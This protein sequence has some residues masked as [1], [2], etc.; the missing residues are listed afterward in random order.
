MKLELFDEFEKYNYQYSSVIFRLLDKN[1]DIMDMILS[2]TNLIHQ[3]IEN[4]IKLY[5]IEPHINNKTAKDLKIDNTHKLEKLLNK[6]ELK[7]YY[8]GI[9]DGEKIYEQY[10]KSVLYFYEILGEDSFLHSRYP[11]QKEKNVITVKKEVDYDELYR[12]WTEYSEAS[13]KISCMYMAYIMSNTIIYLKQ[14]GKVKN[15]LEESLYIQEMMKEYFGIL[16]SLILQEE[17][18]EIFNLT[19][20]FIKRNKYFDMRYVC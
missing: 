7:K 5:I 20:D 9:Q 11:I 1:P 16:E 14:E 13:G 19:K 10:K 18:R 2:L 8:E 3:K 15:E 4:E 17:K 6:E 12:K